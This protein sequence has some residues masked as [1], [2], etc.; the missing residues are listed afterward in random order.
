MFC[1]HVTRDAVLS[2]WSTL[3]SSKESSTDNR[4]NMFYH[5]IQD[6]IAQRNRHG[7]HLQ[8]PAGDPQPRVPLC[9]CAYNCIIYSYL[10][11]FFV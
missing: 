8:L 3:K 5:E 4:T 6:A 9:A 2:D 11:A 1:A 7:T 10:W